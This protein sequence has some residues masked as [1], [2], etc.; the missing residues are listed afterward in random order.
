MGMNLINDYL[1]YSNSIWG[2]GRRVLF[3][4]ELDY[5]VK[6]KGTFSVQPSLYEKH[7]EIIGAVFKREIKKYFYSRER[8]ITHSLLKHGA[9][10]EPDYQRSKSQIPTTTE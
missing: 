2:Y 5:E 1:I 6:K 9:I 7:R 3:N 8:N 10:K 4:L